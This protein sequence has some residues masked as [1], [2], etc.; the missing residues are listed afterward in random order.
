MRMWRQRSFLQLRAQNLLEGEEKWIIRSSTICTACQILDIQF[1]EN[2][3][4][5]ACDMNGRQKN[6]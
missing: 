5:K 2:L 4:G 1:K 6:A 3:I